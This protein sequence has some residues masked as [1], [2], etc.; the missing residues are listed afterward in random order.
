MRIYE[1]I[2]SPQHRPSL[3][4]KKADKIANATRKKSDAFHDY[5]AK[6]KAAKASASDAQAKQAEAKLKYERKRALA[7]DAIRAA[8]ALK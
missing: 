5:Q 6:M 4:A 3:P 7:D 8:L 1:I 2:S